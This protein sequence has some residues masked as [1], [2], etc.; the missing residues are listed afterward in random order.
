M[1]KFNKNAKIII[2]LLCQLLKNKHKIFEEIW[3]GK[4]ITGYRNYKHVVI[5]TSMKHSELQ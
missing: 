2:S 5:N 3:E 1:R 4:D